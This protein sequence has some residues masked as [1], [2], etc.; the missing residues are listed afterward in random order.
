MRIRTLFKVV[1]FFCILGI[2]NSVFAVTGINECRY[3]HKKIKKIFNGK[4]SVINI[5]TIDP[6]YND[7]LV[8]PS[9]GAYYL[10]KKNSVLKIAKQ[11]KAIAAINASYFKPDTGAPLGVSI[12]D[13]E[14]L[15]GPLFNRVVFGVFD[16]G[17]FAIEK[18]DIRGSVSFGDNLNFFLHNINQP[19]LNNRMFNVFTD[20][21]GDKTP[22]TS[23]EFVHIA[24]KAGKIDLIKRSSI[25]IPKG[26]YAVVGPHKFV[27][28]NIHKNDDVSYSLQLFPNKWSS[29]KYAVSG[30]P[31][32]VKE[33]RVFVDKQKF[34]NAFLKEKAPRTAIGYTK[35]NVLILVVVD[36][37][38][39]NYSAGV[40]LFELAQVMK[41]L[42]AY[43]AMNLDGGKSSQM[44]VDGK[45]VNK[46]N[47]KGGLAVTNALLIIQ[48]PSL[49]T[50]NA[51]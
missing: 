16:N 20:R 17:D 21:W 37:R 35:D 19:V 28:K 18:L 12:I 1:L 47:T 30:G 40:S 22:K 7:I 6:K 5:F 2:C 36:G 31:Y 29:A 23:T 45:I 15:T 14:V 11:E 51:L 27:A 49:N 43:N 10:N 13:G 25:K 41:D 9:F 50:D 33:G 42:G 3:E 26:G 48:K 34:S 24:V 39:K 38:R 8:K 46:P 4:P 44:V 32:L